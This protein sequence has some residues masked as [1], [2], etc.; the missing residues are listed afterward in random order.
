M[1]ESSAVLE[2]SSGR[3]GAF[4]C[5]TMDSNFFYKTIS[6]EEAKVMKELA[7]EYSRVP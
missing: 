1:I 3:S 5:P 4:F 2:A 6:K 7:P